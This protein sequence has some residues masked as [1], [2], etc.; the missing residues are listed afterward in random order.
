MV[1]II[2][3]SFAG[4]AFILTILVYFVWKSVNKNS[5]GFGLN[6]YKIVIKKVKKTCPNLKSRKKIVMPLVFFFPMASLN[7]NN[8]FQESITILT[9]RM[10]VA[11][12]I[13][14]LYAVT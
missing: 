12:S 4:M 2:Q 7:E 6:M 14:D 3:P 5:I 8:L 10:N 9:A 11:K 1:S 13:L